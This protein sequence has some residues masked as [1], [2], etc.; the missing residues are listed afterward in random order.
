MRSCVTIS[1]V[2]QARGGPFVFWDGLDDGCA[3]A[4]E[5]GFDAVEVFAPAAEAIDVAHLRQLCT[6]HGLE[7][8]AFGT[9]GGA[10]IHGWTLTDDDAE[11]RGKAK[12]FIGGILERAGEFGAGAIVGSM[13]G[14]WGGGLDRETAR[15]RLG[16]ALA[17]LG[18]RADEVGATL[19][20]EPLNRYE[21]NL[22]NTL[23]D[24]IELCESAGATQVRL[25]ADLFHMN[26]EEADLPA[27]LRAAGAWIGHVHFADS[28]RRAVG[29]GHTDLAAIT[30]ALRAIDYGG[31]LSA[32]VFPWPD[33]RGAAEQ[34]I[35]AFREHTQS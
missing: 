6:T 17:E 31:Y 29:H 7:L 34:T 11:V 9:G 25:L 5:L 13:Q 2:E 19:I 8:A 1:L 26:I 4:A 14:R 33:S 12:A 20:F 35:R 15:R 27:A 21:S 23:A 24:A 10:V 16:E 30:E 18:A 28:N 3:V 32:E 22:S